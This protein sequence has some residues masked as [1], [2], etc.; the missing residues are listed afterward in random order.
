MVDFTGANLNAAVRR[1]YIFG[2]NQINSIL[3][4]FHPLWY[5]FPAQNLC[6]RV[7]KF[8]SFLSR[9]PIPPV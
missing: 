7:K 8:I 4:I 6:R 3:C 9:T 2:N 5:R 1:Q